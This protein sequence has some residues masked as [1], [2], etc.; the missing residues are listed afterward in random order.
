[1]ST[2]ENKRKVIKNKAKEATVNIKV[3]TGDKDQKTKKSKKQ[4]VKKSTKQKKLTYLGSTQNNEENNSKQTSPRPKIN[5]T[6]L[7][8]K[9][10]NIQ[11]ELTNEKKLCIQE[12]SNYNEKI[13]TKAKEL[14][15]LNSQNDK[16]VK[17]LKNLTIKLDSQL[18][19]TNLLLIEKNKK[20]PVKEKDVQYIIDL[21]QSEIK[22]EEKYSIYRQ[23]ELKRYQDLL[24]ENNTC[25]IEETLNSYLNEAEEKIE[26]LNKEIKELKEIQITHNQCPKSKTMLL[27]KYNLLLNDY[28]FERKKH[29]MLKS[30]DLNISM[31]DE[32]SKL[33]QNTISP[34]NRSYDENYY[35]HIKLS[36]KKYSPFAN[37][38][39]KNKIKYINKELEELNLYTNNKNDVGWIQ[40]NKNLFSLEENKVLKNIVPADYLESYNQRY[41]SLLGK[42][43]EASQKFQNNEEIKK[44][45]K[46]QKEKIEA[47]ILN[48]KTFIQKNAT[49]NNESSKYKRQIVEIKGKIKKLNNTIKKIKKIIAKKTEEG[50]KI[51]TK[52]NEEK[53]KRKSKK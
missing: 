43:N 37:I 35:R 30:N 46:K 8:E 21:K 16:L 51:R 39:R 6:E 48:N 7:E 2:S 12:T 15:N 32:T 11:N 29:N 23:A 19:E 3:S 31:K 47:L 49:L 4:S 50:N 18:S 25:N 53:E 34:K 28:E 10:K 41:K 26:N 42:V 45:I 9:L 14:S 5:L 24:E 36:E 33:S 20:K 22:V 1:M 52:I 44:E 27:N 17:K 13:K 38:L 40:Y